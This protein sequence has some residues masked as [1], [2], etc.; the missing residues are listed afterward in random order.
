MLIW[1]HAHLEQAGS[2]LA[3][4]PQELWRDVGGA[5]LAQAR[6]GELLNAHHRQT[7]PVRGMQHLLPQG[8]QDSLYFL[9]GVP[10]RLSQIR[11]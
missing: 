7:C 1:G 4:P 10:L 3:Q 6:V 9:L 11:S 2:T 5:A 8:L